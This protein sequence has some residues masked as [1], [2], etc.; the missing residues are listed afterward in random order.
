MHY[1][2]LIQWNGATPFAL[3]IE[4][5]ALRE[6]TVGIP[7]PEQCIEQSIQ[8]QHYL[9]V[10][11]VY[12]TSHRDYPRSVAAATGSPSGTSSDDDIMM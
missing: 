10:E 9:L 5:A 8:H 4:K 3:I 12:N 6:N 7:T 11:H 2:R 1:C